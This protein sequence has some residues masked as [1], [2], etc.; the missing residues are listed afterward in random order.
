MNVLDD[1]FLRV[2]TR[3]GDAALT[4]PG[5]LA[6]A[7][8]D[9]IV[10]LTGVRPHQ[11]HPVHAFLVQLASIAQSRHAVTVECKD[12]WRDALLRLADG[13]PEAWSL[14]APFDRPA[15]L[16]AP[17]AG[18]EKALAKLI[19]TP[20]ALDILVSS[21][22]HDVKSEVMRNASPELWFYALI[23]L[24]TSDG[25]LGAGNF[26]ISRANGGFSNRC[27]IGVAP[28][29]GVGAHIKRDVDR[30]A[31]LRSEIARRHGYNDRSGIGLTW[32]VPWDG[33]T[34]IAVKDLDPCYIEICR[35]VRL[36]VDDAGRLTA[37]AGS[38]KC[39]R[40]ET[41]PGGVT[42]DPWMPLVLEKDGV[43][44]LTVDASGF[45][46]QRLVKLLFDDGAFRKAPLQEF[47]ATDAETGLCIVA[48]AFVRG[49]GKT[50]G[51]HER[52]IPVSRVMMR[53]TRE[54]A[55]DRAAAIAHDRVRQAGDL[56]LKVLK[57]AILMLLQNGPDEI[58]R[59]NVTS[60]D[61]ADR[62][63]RQLDEF[64]DR[65]FFP[66]LWQEVEAADIGEDEMRQARLSWQ[67]DIVGYARTILAD[68]DAS[69]PK[70]G[71]R[72]YRALAKAESLFGAQA[73]KVFPDAMQKKEI[74][75][76]A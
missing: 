10:S 26:G 56:E 40:V 19:R 60:M 53:R 52:R 9:D 58:N 17:V 35:R 12:S 5:L 31:D 15:F 16:Q 73:H 24:Q 71:R 59:K 46:Y 45:G 48:R 69:S 54:I 25:Y 30:L 23:S 75:D 64:V 70:A 32:L 28:P 14:T 21:K 39:T 8:R 4:L 72:R 18:D 66:A 42:G 2:R 27:G 20:D 68:V 41:Q 76:A 61:R 55:L 3:N 44:A 29:G 7:F 57:P 43:K 34:Q 74:D 65:S 36:Q 67:R 22:N 63:V 62:Y 50:E 11:R 47:A 38:S 1:S 6:A 13:R 51:Y 33:A 49:Q 37:R